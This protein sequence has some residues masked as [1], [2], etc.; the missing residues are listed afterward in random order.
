MSTKSNEAQ[1]EAT[2]GKKN[3]SP[4]D[5]FVQS[6]LESREVAEAFFKA[7]LSPKLVQAI[8]WSTFAIYDTTRRGKGKNIAQHRHHLPRQD[9][10]S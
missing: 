1:S 3:P 9:Q 8:N 6:V 5:R 7:H 2:E 10:R 4:H